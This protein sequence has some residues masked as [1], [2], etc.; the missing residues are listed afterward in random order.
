M[1]IYLNQFSK[2]D[3]MI[4]LDSKGISFVLVLDYIEEK[5]LYNLFHN[6]KYEYPTFNFYTLDI[7]MNTGFITL[8]TDS[9]LT[10]RNLPLLMF[11][12][13]NN[14]LHIFTDIFI[15][16]NIDAFIVKCKNMVLDTPVINNEYSS[17]KYSKKG[18]DNIIQNMIDCKRDNE[19]KKKFSH[20][21]YTIDKHV[22]LKPKNKPYLNK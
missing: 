22:I 18:L 17:K 2:N 7:T 5:V 3:R 12:Y 14:L 8:C 11:F 19:Y 13:D 4:K 1:N 15:L 10:L 21:E 9:Q 6:L 20:P 16:A